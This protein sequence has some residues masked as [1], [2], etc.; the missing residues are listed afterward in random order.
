MYW[1]NC[2]KYHIFGSYTMSRYHDIL[3]ETKEKRRK[4]SRMMESR[5]NRKALTTTNTTGD[6]QY[7]AVEQIPFD[8]YHESVRLIG[9]NNP[10]CSPGKPVLTYED[11]IEEGTRP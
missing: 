2:C 6:T 1:N 9:C 4:G 5:N 11:G 3:K 7:F 8:H 10:D